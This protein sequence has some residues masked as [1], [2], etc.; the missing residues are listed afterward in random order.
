MAFLYIDTNL[1]RL[2]VVIEI[3]TTAVVA[4]EKVNSIVDT[5]ITSF[6]TNTSSS[7]TN[8]G[9]YLRKRTIFDWLEKRV[10]I[11]HFMLV[12]HQIN[13]EK[14]MDTNHPEV[15]M[16]YE[17]GY[18]HKDGSVWVPTG[19]GGDNPEGKVS[20]QSSLRCSTSPKQE[21]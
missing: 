21:W 8:T 5:V 1:H 11:Y 6:S 4:T 2:V 10:K 18:P 12:K 7:T 20:W 17:R 9:L 15:G 3:V 19:E 13:Q 16:V 14:N